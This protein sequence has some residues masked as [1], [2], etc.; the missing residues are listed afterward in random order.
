MYDTHAA[1]IFG[2]FCWVSSE[3]YG[4]MQ[5]LCADAGDGT[6]AVAVWGPPIAEETWAGLLRLML[7]LAR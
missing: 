2:Y 7:M 4:G 5:I 6:V 3:S 1:D